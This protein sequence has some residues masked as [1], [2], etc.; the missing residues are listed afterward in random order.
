MNRIP[1]RPVEEA[2]HMEYCRPPRQA[3]TPS[4]TLKCPTSPSGTTALSWRPAAVARDVLAGFWGVLTV[5][6]L[7]LVAGWA[8]ERWGHWLR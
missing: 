2:G 7:L 5:A 3:G 6:A 4:N 8:W 1:L